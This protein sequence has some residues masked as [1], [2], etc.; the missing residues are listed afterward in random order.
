MMA[1][2]RSFLANAPWLIA[3]PA[4]SITLTVVSISAIGRELLRRSE[5]KPL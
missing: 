2:G 5:G 4:L 3:W 1:I